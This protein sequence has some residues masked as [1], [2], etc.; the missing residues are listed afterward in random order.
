[1]G[2]FVVSL[3]FELH[4]GVRDHRTVADYR[5]NLLG[6]RRVVPALLELFSEYG[7]RATWATVGFLFFESKDELMSAL[8]KE[9]PAYADKRLD[10][11]SALD[12]VGENESSDP[13]HFAPTLIRLIKD[14]PEQEIATHTFS[15]FYAMA[16][17]PSLESFRADIRLAIATG[18]RF[19]VEIKSIVFPRNQVTSDHVRICA[20]EGLTAYRGVESDPLVAAGRGVVARAKRFVDS[21]VDLAGPGCGVAKETDGLGVVSVPQSRFLRPYDPGSSSLDGLRLRRILT[22]MTFAAQ[23][24]TLFHL[25]WHPHNFG[26][27]MDQ[28]ISFLRSILDHYKKLEGKFDFHSATMAEVSERVLASLGTRCQVS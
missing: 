15:H 20:E 17:G 19:G 23:N 26:K 8:P 2:T 4:W 28:N 3:D 27:N 14:A 7:I 10:P 11:Y 12:E 9:R 18:R 21:Y 24:Q 25:W 16:A 1:V 22:S 13:F 5:E 6:V